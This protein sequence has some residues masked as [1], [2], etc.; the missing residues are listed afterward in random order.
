MK[1][2]GIRFRSKMRELTTYGRIK[3]GKLKISYRDRFIEA[4][5]SWPDCRIILIVKKQFRQRS[6]PQNAFLHGVVFP[7]M[8]LALIEAGYSPAEMS[9]PKVKDWLKSMFAKKEIANEKT[10]EIITII[11]PTHEMSTVE[12]MDFI[13]E[14]QKFAAEMFNHF[15]PSPGEQLE[16]DL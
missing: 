16:A 12:M 11:Q 14:I 7:E 15:I 6:T 13:A 1:R 10:G 8:R 5:K 4:L 2:P 9:E 3:S